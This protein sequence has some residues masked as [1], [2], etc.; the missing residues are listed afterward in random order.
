MSTLSDKIS[1]GGP[2]PGLFMEGPLRS[3]A[4]NYFRVVVL[5]RT[6]VLPF[7]PQFPLT[8]TKLA[9]SA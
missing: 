9:G 2:L 4:Q 1:K 5:S 7:R 8:G 6:F 3:R